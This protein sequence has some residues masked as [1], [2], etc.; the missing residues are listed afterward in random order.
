MG[1]LELQLDDVHTEIQRAIADAHGAMMSHSDEATR[2]VEKRLIAMEEKQ[3]YLISCFHKLFSESQE[4]AKI[5]VSHVTDVTGA[6]EAK[7]DEKVQFS[8]ATFCLSCHSDLVGTVFHESKPSVVATEA[9]SVVMEPDCESPE[10]ANSSELGMIGT[11]PTHDV[12]VD[13]GVDR[14]LF[15]ASHETHVEKALELSPIGNQ[16]QGYID[17]TADGILSECPDDDNSVIGPTFEAIELHDCVAQ[18]SDTSIQ[19]VS[20]TDET[21]GAEDLPPQHPQAVS[22]LA[23]ADD[24]L[25]ASEALSEPTV[26]SP[27]PGDAVPEEVPAPP[28]TSQMRMVRAIGSHLDK[29][30][31]LLSPSKALVFKAQ[32]RLEAHVNSLP[33][34]EAEAFI[35][36]VGPTVLELST[37][38]L[39]QMMKDPNVCKML[40]IQW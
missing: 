4:Q 14:A 40:G 12:V 32:D 36:K 25:L 21:V 20:G 18:I 28:E 6:Q 22:A 24:S 3:D 5:K 17:L 16:D 29:A 11:A 27:T 30:I 37:D 15:V 1:K 23:P 10:V 19:S 34:H 33:G 31:R 38:D 2:F 39:A 26:A 35:A 7:I 9:R 8:E 13:D